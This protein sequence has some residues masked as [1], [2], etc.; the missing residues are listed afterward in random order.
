M[1][2]VTGDDHEFCTGCPNL[3]YL[4]P[5]M[6]DSLCV[7]SRIEGAPATAAAELIASVRIEFHPV[8]MALIHDV[9]GLIIIPVPEPFFRFPAV[10]TRIVV[11]C[12]SVKS[13]PIQLYSA[14]FN[15]FDDQIEDGEGAECSTFFRIPLFKTQPGR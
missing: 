15:V 10:I 9:S 14:F 5:P 11:R 12:Q 6:V 2:A 3:V 1:A 8:L 4:F 7:I 13:I